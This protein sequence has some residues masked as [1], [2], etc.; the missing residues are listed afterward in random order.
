M[1]YGYSWLLSILVRLVAD[2][3]PYMTCVIPLQAWHMKSYM[4]YMLLLIVKSH[5]VS[6]TLGN[7]LFLSTW[8]LH[9]Q[10]LRTTKLSPYLQLYLF[11]EKKLYLSLTQNANI[12]QLTTT[13]TRYVKQANPALMFGF[14]RTNCHLTIRFKCQHTHKHIDDITTSEKK[15]V[16]KSNNGPT[17]LLFNRA[18]TILL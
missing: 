18:L 2:T 12:S 6:M 10:N 5:Q 7:S 11:C 14:H 4:L 15:S 3:S 9:L 13:W 16:K 1:S 17:Q 8:S